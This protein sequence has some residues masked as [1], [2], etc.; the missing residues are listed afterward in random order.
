MCLSLC[1]C[2][3]VSC[4]EPAPIFL[5][6]LVPLELLLN[7]VDGSLPRLLL[8]CTEALFVQGQYLGEELLGRS[9]KVYQG[10]NIIKPDLEIDDLVI[11]CMVN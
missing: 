9:K 7:G 8:G 2:F 1:L 10:K 6:C 11:Q 5:S 3:L 4:S